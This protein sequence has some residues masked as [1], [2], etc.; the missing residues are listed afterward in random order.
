MNK[1]SL[2]PGDLRSHFVGDRKKNVF[3]D[4]HPAFLSWGG[5][6]R[7]AKSV[8]PG[9][10][11]GPDEGPVRSATQ[12]ATRD[13]VRRGHDTCHAYIARRVCIVAGRGC[14]RL[15]RLRPGQPSGI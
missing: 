14:A 5:L 7:A 1:M 6:P 9:G 3:F 13:D 8:V 10:G 11:D 4:S 12:I 15:F 2:P